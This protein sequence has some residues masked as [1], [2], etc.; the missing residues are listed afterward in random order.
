MRVGQAQKEA[1]VNEAHIIADAMMHCVV[2]GEASSPPASTTDGECWL[3]GANAS[4]A[5]TGQS[6]KI[7][8]HNGGN[9]LFMMPSHG[10]R[11]FDRSTE[12]DLRYNGTW[13]SPEAP[14][15]PSGGGVIDTEA[16][17]AIATLITQLRTAGIFAAL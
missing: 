14:A 17:T 1:H 3:I 9:W 15:S 7:A 8:C 11:V 10:M 16:R 6:G 12:H 2:A 4:G 13:L 5:W